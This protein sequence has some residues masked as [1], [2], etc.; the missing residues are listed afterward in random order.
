MSSYD[1]VLP[2]EEARLRAH[3]F[4][5]ADGVV[6]ELPVLSESL[7]DQ[8]SDDEE[9]LFWAIRRDAAIVPLVTEDGFYGRLHS[10]PAVAVAGTKNG[11]RLEGLER[12]YIRERSLY[13]CR[14]THPV[15]GSELLDHLLHGLRGVP[16]L[17]VLAEAPAWPAFDDPMVMGYLTAAEVR[18]LDRVA[19]TLGE[20]PHEQSLRTMI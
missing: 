13:R 9:H 1:C 10:S 7:R 14:W 6:A 16:G 20:G 19:R 2:I 15:A 17:R 3:V 8:S 4:R 18:E 5:W 12:I 11:F